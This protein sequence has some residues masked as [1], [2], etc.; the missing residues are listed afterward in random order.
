MIRPTC[1]DTFVIKN[2]NLKN[3]YH[4][5]ALGPY[6]R[7]C[8]CQPGHFVHIKLP[9]ADVFF[10]RALSIAHVPSLNRIEI[11]LKVLGRGTKV[12]A[13]LRQGDPVNLL[14]PLGTPFKLPKKNETALI[15]AGGIG[16]PP[17]LFLTYEMI[18]RG[19]NPKQI[20]FFYGGRSAVDIVEH[21][22]IKKMGVTFQPVTEDGSLGETGLVT[23]SIEKHLLTRRS[24]RF[25]IYGCGPPGM[26]K[27]TNDLGLKHGI[28][29]QLSLEAPMPCGI[30][31]CL[32][33]VVELT[34]G[35]HARVCCD[36]P[37]FDIGEV[38]L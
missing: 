30:G 37:V 31:V 34:K 4:S 1:E 29:G 19:R 33:C 38:V 5:L 12:M 8:H 35:G 16:L 24:D 21:S 9:T 15:I 13:G 25:R 20:V 23:E 11:I 3:D 14:G 26:L 17:L 27:A 6:S 2:R 10:R 22:R 7:A 32:G 18:K 36:G 28:P